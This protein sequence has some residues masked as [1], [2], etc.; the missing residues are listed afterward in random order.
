VWCGTAGGGADAITLSPSPAIT[1]YAAGQRFVWM[2]SGSTNTGA[3]TV[4]ISGLTA[5]A[6]QDNG[7]ALT[8]GQHAA[9]KM[10]MGILNTTSTV[11]IMQVQVSG[12]DPLIV[13][14]LDVTGVAMA[15]T[16]EP[17]GDTSA[18]D[19]AALGYTSVLGAILTGQ[20]STNDVTLVNDAD[21]TVLGIPTGT[22]NVDI[23]GTA[24]AATFEPDG[25][26]AA[27]D[28]AAIGYTSAEGLILTGQGSTDD[29]TVKND[30]DTTVLN[31]GTGATDVEV[32]AGNLLFGTASKG[33]YLGVT[34]ATAANLL[35]D[36]EFGNWTCTIVGSTGNPSSDQTATG[37]YTKTGLDVHAEVYIANKDTSGASG[38]LKFSGLPFA[39]ST[40]AVGSIALY[41]IGAANS[42]GAWARIAG[43]AT[44]VEPRTNVDG[45]PWL[46]TTISAGSGRYAVIDVHYRTA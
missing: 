27:A 7:A 2:S 42:V 18:G 31:V 17:D 39:A 33:V 11:Q 41:N 26:T 9:G 35:D 30:A 6:L 25:D 19:N 44:I 8:A 36:Y 4:A 29:I 24:T 43:S 13:S 1:A 12:T 5:I 3:T 23:V 45:N 21:A 20:G 37:T 22:T 14:S 40:V 34:S 16:F 38:S 46:A 32:S 10:F 15:A 28:N